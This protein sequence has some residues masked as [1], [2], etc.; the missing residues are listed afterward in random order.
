MKEAPA[1]AGDASSP[2]QV[3][4]RLFETDLAVLLRMRLG[5]ALPQGR[6]IINRALNREAMWVEQGSEFEPLAGCLI[7]DPEPRFLV[8][9]TGAPSE[10]GEPL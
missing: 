8:I 6:R 10:A 7:A 9:H 3:R 1:P 2:D 5:E 4:G